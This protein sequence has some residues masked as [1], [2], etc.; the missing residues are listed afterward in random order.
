MIFNE[1]VKWYDELCAREY[2]RVKDSRSSNDK[3]QA[4]KCEFVRYLL[5]SLP[6]DTVLKVESARGKSDRPFV[7]VNVGSLIEC[8][9]NKHLAHRQAA[10]IEKQWNDAA[11]DTRFGKCEYEIK[12]SAVSNSRCTPVKTDLPVILVNRSG[13]S[14]IKHNDVC[15]YTDSGG[16]LPEVGLFGSRKHPI[17]K[18][19][20]QVLG[21]EGGY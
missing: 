4:K 5:C 20:E 11:A 7:F 9:V 17:T 1:N 18:Y 19:L 8:V 12:F 3:K 2:D 21:L 15:N 13:V 10:A 6:N 16:S 14:V